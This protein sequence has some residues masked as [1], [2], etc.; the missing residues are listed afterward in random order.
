MLRARTDGRESCFAPATSHSQPEHRFHSAIVSTPPPSTLGAA[1]LVADDRGEA[2]D[3]RPPSTVA[4][5]WII[6][7]GRLASIKSA[8][9]SS[10]DLPVLAVHPATSGERPRKRRAPMTIAPNARSRI[11]LGASRPKRLRAAH[12]AGLS[13]PATIPKARKRS[14]TP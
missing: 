11:V 4:T 12:S 6:E 8:A 2:Q 7:L 1:P 9:I 10:I 5:R 13:R 14:S 3:W